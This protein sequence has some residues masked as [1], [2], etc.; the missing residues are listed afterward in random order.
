MAESLARETS[1]LTGDWLVRVPP[2][3]GH[4]LMESTSIGV[5][6]VMSIYVSIGFRL[7]CIVGP[8]FEV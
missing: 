4:M 2:R 7:G 3:T 8:R 5:V 1:Y 6:S